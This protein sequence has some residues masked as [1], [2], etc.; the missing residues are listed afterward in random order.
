MARP[1]LHTKKEDVCLNSP[2]G[3]KGDVKG[4]GGAGGVGRRRHTRGVPWVGTARVALPPSP[5]RAGHGAQRPVS[6]RE[7]QREGKLGTGVAPA[8]PRGPLRAPPGG[9][10][11]ATRSRV[12]TVTSPPRSRPYSLRCGARAGCK[13]PSCRRRCGK[14][15]HRE[16]RHVA[17][18]SPPPPPQP[19]P[20]SPPAPST[21]SPTLSAR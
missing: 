16:R 1:E 8:S 4:D 10:D 17:R 18:S 14:R 5:G 9:G 21:L 3:D 13:S 6:P 11:G 15:E 7:G 20:P 19:P 2:C 12:G